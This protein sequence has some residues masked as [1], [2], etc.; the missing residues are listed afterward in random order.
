MID[1][2]KRDD[3]PSQEEIESFVNSVYNFAGD[4]IVNHNF[5]YDDAK[6]ALVEQGL[7]AADAET[8]VENIKGQIKEAK[9]E[10]AN[11]ALLYGFL[12]AAGGL[13]L[14]LITNGAFIFYGAVIYG[15]IL[16]VKGCWHKIN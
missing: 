11:K 2:D 1:L 12:W 6:K 7:N 16:I 5:S 9:S 3:I 8:V 4:L 10:A 15:I 13:I 14:T